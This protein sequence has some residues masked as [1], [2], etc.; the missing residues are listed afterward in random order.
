[1]G[2]NLHPILSWI[3]TT[4][5]LKTESK[6]MNLNEQLRQAYED[7]RR[8]GLNEQ[9][10][11]APG[12]MGAKIKKTSLSTSARPDA[13]PPTK[14]WDWSSQYILDQVRQ[15]Y[16]Q[17]VPPAPAWIDFNGDGVIGVDD[18][19]HALGEGGTG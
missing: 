7:G 17:S 10:G 5:T 1:L 12:D 14:D 15:W 6:Q 2:I 13:L 16:G 9:G 19:L 3:T 8:Q 18:L 11:M 4:T